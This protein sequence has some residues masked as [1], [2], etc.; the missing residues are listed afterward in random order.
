MPDHI[1]VSNEELRA[2]REHASI[3]DDVWIDDE[4]IRYAISYV[5]AAPYDTDADTY[6]YD[7]GYIDSVAIEVIQRVMARGIPAERVAPLQRRIV[8]IQGRQ[9][10]YATRLTAERLQQVL[11]E[12]GAYQDAAEVPVASAGY[13][14]NLAPTDDDLQKVA[15]KFDAFTVDSE[16]LA[17][18]SFPGLPSE[19][20][21]YRRY[22]DTVAD[23]D[24]DSTPFAF[25]VKRDGQYLSR[26]SEGDPTQYQFKLAHSHSAGITPTIT[27]NDSGPIHTCLLYTSPSPRDRTRSRMPSSA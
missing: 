11:D 3:Y 18:V 24:M 1:Q 19:L 10:R 26:I 25:S 20:Y 16:P 6:V 5:G 27:E 2:I 21:I 23:Y 7:E 9:T 14:G 17:D 13:T 22:F 8:D 4:G 15:D 12:H